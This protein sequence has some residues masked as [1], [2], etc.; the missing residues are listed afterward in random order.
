MLVKIQTKNNF[1]NK[2]INEVCDCRNPQ[3]TD[4]IYLNSLC[5]NPFF[6]TV[7]VQDKLTVPQC[8]NGLI[9][10]T[11]YNINIIY[12]QQCKST[13]VLLYNMKILGSIIFSWEQVLTINYRPRPFIQ[14]VQGQHTMYVCTCMYGKAAKA[15]SKRIEMSFAKVAIS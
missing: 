12:S 11:Q 6:R 2:L 15:A 3:R 13:N 4:T 14:H 1:S 9:F 5:K 10:L 8:D 7:F